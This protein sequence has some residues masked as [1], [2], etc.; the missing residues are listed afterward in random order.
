MPQ[1]GVGQSERQTQNRVI[2][3]FRDE[4]GYR[5]LGDWTDRQNNSNIEEDLL[6]AHLSRSGY[7]AV[8]ISRTLDRLRAEAMRCALNGDR[9]SATGGGICVDAK[10]NVYD[11]I[12]QKSGGLF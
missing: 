1:F 8:Q 5:V 12:Y 2:A 11:I 4:L 7:S 3:L 9:M 6:T 10:N